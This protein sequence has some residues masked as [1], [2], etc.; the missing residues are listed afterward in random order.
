MLG[1]ALL[2]RVSQHTGDAEAA[3]LAHAAMTYSC[4]R[5]RDDGAWFYGELPKY[6]WIDNFHTG[7][8][9]DSL[10]RYEDSI[11]VGEF[12]GNLQTGF[13]YF[14]QT[15][16]EADGRPRYY[17]NNAAPTDIQCAAQSIDT[18]T[19]FSAIDPDSLELAQTVAAWTIDHMQG[20]DGHFYYR[21][22]GWKK[23]KTPM[24]HWGQATMF[25]AMAHLF[26][27]LLN[28]GKAV[29]GA[30]KG[31]AGSFRGLR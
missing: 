22:L 13:Q 29:A 21:D 12:S 1:A 8:N 31:A 16:F 20:P 14:K 23:I 2:A 6:H 7:Y 24:L 9:L 10:K 26:A 30:A 27:R 11:G 15:F 28:S 17:H 4:A 3:E 25:K 5:Q 19:Y 18:L